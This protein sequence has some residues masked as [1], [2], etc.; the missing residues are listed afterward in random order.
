MNLYLLI[1]SSD[2]NWIKPKVTQH[3]A[4]MTTQWVQVLAAKSAV[5]IHSPGLRWQRENRAPPV[6]SAWA[7]KINKWKNR[8]K[9]EFKNYTVWAKLWVYDIGISSDFR[10]CQLMA[11]EN[12]P[13]LEVLCVLP[14]WA[15]DYD[16]SVFCGYP[17][18][19]SE[20]M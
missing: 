1:A 3:W 10:I 2:I 9:F 11:S 19:A 18:S 5:W 15:I 13:G 12:P 8:F 17:F 16:H 4:G 7:H 6:V 14:L 20:Y